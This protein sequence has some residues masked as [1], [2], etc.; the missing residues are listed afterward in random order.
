M[1]TSPTVRPEYVISDAIAA[2]INAATF[3]GPITSLPATVDEIADPE[4]LD[5]PANTT[6]H[7]YV[8]PAPELDI[9]LAESRGGD[10]HEIIVLVILTKRL[11][12]DS[13]RRSLVDLR[14][15]LQDRLRIDRE[16]T[17]CLIASVP[18]YWD[19]REI[20]VESTFSREG[21]R[22]ARVFSGGLRLKFAAMLS[23]AS[24]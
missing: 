20:N 13:E 12:S 23:R 6:P 10:L 19:L 22:G 15:Q 21:L 8:V 1:P 16:A 3:T 5:N 17:G 18:L 9:S 7:V 4:N 14:W 11:S 24:P 2:A